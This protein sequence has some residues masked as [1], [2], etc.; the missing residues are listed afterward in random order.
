M[1]FV[2]TAHNVGTS[3]FSVNCT[4]TLNG[5]EDLVA[6]VTGK[7]IYVEM[8][9][10]MAAAD[11]GTITI[12]AGETAGAVTAPIIGPVPTGAV[13]TS[14]GITTGISMNFPRPIKLAAAIALTV[15]TSADI[16]C[17]IVVQGYIK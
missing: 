11:G 4:G 9:A 6:A 10:I 16:A 5:C 13:T 1:A 7:S 12:G 8:V 14:G 2:K 15:D 17:C 3:G